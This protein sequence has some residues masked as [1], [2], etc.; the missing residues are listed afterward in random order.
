MIAVTGGSGFVGR[1]VL[2]ELERR[3]LEYRAPSHR[4]LDVLSP[5]SDAFQ[6]LGRPELLLHLAWGGLPAYQS[7]HHLETELPGQ[8][9]FLQGLVGA[10]LKR[11]L[12]TG[13]CL[14]YG[15][16]SGPLA[17]DLEPQPVTA[18][19]RAKDRLRCQLADL[20]VELVWAR[21]FYLHGEGQR[22]TSLW[23]ALELAVAERQESFPMASG[24]RLRDYLSVTEAASALVDRALGPAG[25]FNVCSGRPIAMSALVEG[26]LAENGWSIR[27]EPGRLPSPDYEPEAFW[28]VPG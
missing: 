7:K 20:P 2:R 5:P 12:V 23:G 26:W 10:G 11:V 15:L 18:Y 25:T 24:E 27:L 22:P 4:E 3:G 1:H 16:Q 9:D 14:E 28:G 21:L 6:R 19:G 8:W 17:A 13:S